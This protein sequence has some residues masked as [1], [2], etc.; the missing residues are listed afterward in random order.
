VSVIVDIAGMRTLSELGY[1]G[2]SYPAGT[3]LGCAVNR[4]CCCL[5]AVTK[6]GVL[7]KQTAQLYAVA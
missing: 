6:S 4:R 3:K 7:G 5:V 1:A 2:Y